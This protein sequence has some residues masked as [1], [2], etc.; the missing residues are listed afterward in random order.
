MMNNRKSI[1]AAVVIALATLLSPPALAGYT[2]GMECWKTKDYTCVI[3]EF[4]TEVEAHPEYDYGWS[5]IGNAYLQ[6]KDYGK[7]V[8]NLDKAIALDDAKLNNYTNKAKAY[9]EQ[10]QY[11]KVVATLTGKESMQ[12]AQGEVYSLNHQLGIAHYHEKSFG[13]AIGYLE[14]AAAVKPDFT[15]LYMLGIC[16]DGIGNTDK[17]ISSLKEALKGRPGDGET[18]TELAKMYLELAAKEK[19]KPKKEQYYTDAMKYAQGAVK[20]KS[21]DYT[22]HNLVARAYLGADQYD[23]AE[24]SFKK[25][26]QMKPDYCYAKANL[27]KVYIAQ[28]DW[29]NG[30]K[31]LNEATKCMPDSAVAW[32]SLGFAQE[33]VYKSLSTDQAKISQLNKALSSFQ[34]A[35]SIKDSGSIKTS[36]ERI[37]QNI[38]I[39]NQNIR[40]AEGN[41]STMEKNLEALKRNLAENQ[42]VL[43]DALKQRQFFLDK[44][45]WPDE[46]EQTFVKEKEAIEAS[47]AAI[48]KQIDDQV[49]ELETARSAAKT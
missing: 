23:Q 24:A 11:A 3:R 9:T 41:I 1:V 10:K 12:G 28:K 30:V 48:Q 17:S 19:S 35:A 49:K 16:Y 46:K 6:L 36:I 7:A 22:K 37:N 32:E 21:G 44:D 15:T 2:E 8:E 38:D 39:S 42:K 45:Q 14:K 33:K 18:Q 5:M 25:V 4:Q 20:A 29:N 31:I 40:I 34:K 27:G 47:M 43:D 13:D 26:L